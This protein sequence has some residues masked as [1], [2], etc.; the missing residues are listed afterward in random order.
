MLR[1]P[2][3][4]GEASYENSSISGV[5]DRVRASGAGRGRAED[6]L[7]HGQ[8]A[9]GGEADHARA[10]ARHRLGHGGQRVGGRADRARR[11]LQPGRRAL[12]GCARLRLQ[13]LARAGTP[14]PPHGD[15]ALRPREVADRRDRRDR[16]VAQPLARTRL[17]RA[18]LLA[19]RLR[20]RP[21]R[22]PGRLREREHRRAAAGLPRA[23]RRRR[24]QHGDRVHADLVQRGRRHQHAGADGPLGPHDRHRVDLPDH[25]EPGRHG[26]LRG[27]SGAQPRDEGVHRRPARRP[28]DARDGHLQQQHGPGRRPG[29]L[30]RLPLHPG[31]ARR[32]C[33]RAARARRS[34]T[35]TRGPTR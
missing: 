10:R 30:D 29:R 32:R 7:L 5:R 16:A 18:A 12:R 27:V 6:Q 33:P 14:R 25:A 3:A 20:P 2:Q 35:P 26:A 11:P 1:S 24:G 9:G 31:R 28:P 13:G 19:G 4:P 23:A 8:A 21:A 17:A 34:W 15:G 22:D